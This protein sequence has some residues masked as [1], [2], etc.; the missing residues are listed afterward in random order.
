MTKITLIRQ[1]KI[2]LTAGEEAIVLKFNQDGHRTYV[3][4][5]VYFGGAGRLTIRQTDIWGQ[6]IKTDSTSIAGAGSIYFNLLIYA[7]E[8]SVLI[9]NEATVTHV[10]YYYITTE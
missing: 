5:G 7:Y 1:D 6:N 9:K 8:V 4:G 10:E 3:R 2:S